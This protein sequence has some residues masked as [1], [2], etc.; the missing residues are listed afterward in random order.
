MKPVMIFGVALP[1]PL[2]ISR[3]WSCSGFVTF[4]P[5]ASE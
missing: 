3:P 2:A 1:A 4:A 5:E